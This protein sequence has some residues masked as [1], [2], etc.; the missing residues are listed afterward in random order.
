MYSRKPME[1]NLLHR[2]SHIN[3]IHRQTVLLGRN[4]KD[5]RMES[6]SM[7]EAIAIYMQCAVAEIVP[8]PKEKKRVPNRKEEAEYANREALAIV[9][10][11]QISNQRR[12][13]ARE[14]NK[15]KRERQRKSP[16]VPVGS[17]PEMEEE[18]I[19]PQTPY[20]MLDVNRCA[21]FL[22]YSYDKHGT[23]SILG[24]D[25]KPGSYGGRIT[26]GEFGRK[27]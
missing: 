11:C 8:Q 27:A 22:L 26:N 4:M 21:G 14:R 13:D 12:E 24:E 17:I 9:E 16:G 6:M 15:E 10:V 5:A 23:H 2:L 1:R 18:I 25:I 7:Q 20:D 19:L 3:D